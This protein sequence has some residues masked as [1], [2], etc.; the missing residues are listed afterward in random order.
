MP[1]LICV[2]ALQDARDNASGDQLGVLDGRVGHQDHE[3]VAAVAGN[4]VGR[5][6]VV[7]DGRRDAV[8]HAI[9]VGVTKSIVD[10]LELVEVQHQHAQRTVAACGAS[11]LLA[12]SVLQ[13]TVVVD[14]RHEVHVGRA[15]QLLDQADL[16][17]SGGRQAGHRLRG[18]H[19][20]RVQVAR[21]GERVELNE[22]HRPATCLQ[23][24][25]HQRFATGVS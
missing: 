11:H 16:L 6:D 14:V 20:G 23:R 13:V 25:D 22:A 3:L 9:A 18:V 10:R 19:L 17:E 15:A 1:S 4:H 2:L 21:L 8:E 24:Q 5:S 7:L 12:Q